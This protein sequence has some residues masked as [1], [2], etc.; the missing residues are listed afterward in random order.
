VLLMMC[1]ALVLPVAQPA[2]CRGR[3]LRVVG[4]KTAVVFTHQLALV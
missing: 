4:S 2:E 3:G 1:Q